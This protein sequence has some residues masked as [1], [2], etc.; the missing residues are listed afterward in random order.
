[1]KEI[2][3][4]ITGCRALGDTLCVTPTIRKLY[5]SYNRKVSVITNVP[6]LFVTNP[7]VENIFD[8]DV[9]RD[10]LKETYDIFDTFD[11]SYK[12]NGVCNKHNAMD[13]R[14]F[15]AISLGFMLNKEEMTL[16]YNPLYT[17][18]IPDLPKKYVLIH[19]VQNWNSRTWS[20][21][22]WN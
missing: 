9:N 11:L 2:C 7:Y 18:M 1:M 22:N 16:D 4:D 8:G 14:Q 20:L 5:K 19:S 15:H 6:E 3:L 10:E 12:D 17:P 21:N 13:I